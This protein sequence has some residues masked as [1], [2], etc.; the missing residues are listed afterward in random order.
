M[1][2]RQAFIIIITGLLMPK[3]FDK[4][5]VNYNTS[6]VKDFIIQLPIYQSVIVILFFLS[7]L[8]Q[9]FYY[10]FFY[11]RLTKKRQPRHSLPD[12]EPVTILI[13]ARNEEQNLKA[14]LPS[15]M[16]QNYPNFEVVVVDDCSEDGTA[17]IL[18]AFTQQYKNLKIT[19]IKPDEKF[20]HGKKLALTIGIKA[21][22]NE[23]LLLTDADCLPTDKYWLSHMQENFITSCEVVLGYGGY[24][25]EKGL[26]DKI[27]R[28][29]TFF[30]A[31]NYLSFALAGIPYMG[32]GRN[33][34]YRKSTFFNNKGFASHYMLRSGD[35]DLF[36][37]EVANKKNTLVE[38]RPGTLIES[39]QEKSFGAWIWQKIRHSTTAEHY[40][41]GS[42]YLLW[43]EPIS[44]L[45]F[46]TLFILM[47][48]M[49]FPLYWVG[50]GTYLLRTTIQAIVIKMAQNRLA[51]RNLFIYSLLYDIISPF[52]YAFIGIKKTLSPKWN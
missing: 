8:I 43:I 27:I 9:L 52:L 3:N 5:A 37:N 14:H 6:N 1:K 26:L 35:D 12:Q 13:C 10:L 50:I 28:C 46:Y 34:A 15:I 16:E 36:I 20:S 24:K 18:K 29:D 7:L 31:L 30:I 33:L 39:E 25:Q 38:Y 47:L 49:P 32:V 41:T 42:K 44:R 2:T 19:T 51:E 11:V 21:A 22:K 23:L 4:I 17:D 40:R 48:T 45:T